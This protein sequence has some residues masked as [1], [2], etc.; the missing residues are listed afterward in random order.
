MTSIADIPGVS[1]EPVHHLDEINV[2][3]S[4]LSEG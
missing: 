2:Y 1:D 3:V 4:H